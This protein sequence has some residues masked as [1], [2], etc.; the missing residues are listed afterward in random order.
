MKMNDGMKDVRDQETGRRRGKSIWRVI[1]RDVIKS[2]GKTRLKRKCKLL[3]SK[4]RLMGMNV[5]VK[6]VRKEKT[7]RRR[8]E[9]IEGSLA[10]M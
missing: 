3:E 4:R 7:G 8:G 6:D 10:E 5:E 2:V 1:E 9:N